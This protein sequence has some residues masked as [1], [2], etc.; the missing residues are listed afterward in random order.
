[1]EKWTIYAIVSMIFAGLTSVIAKFGM[2]DLSSDTAL[3]IR[4]SVVFALV[5]TNAFIFKNAYSE[6]QQA[7]AKNWIFLSIS[8]LTTAV[9]WIFYYRA[10]KLGPVSYIASID[11]AS[12]V[13]TLILSF[14]ILKEP[15][16]P[17]I[18]IGGGL[19]LIGM[20]FLIWK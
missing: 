10:M 3:T 18:L 11:K 12:I 17:K 8:G 19:I 15:I 7:P 5:F 2:K 1:M 6:I 4:T 14:L 16:T 9:S 13:V 20:L